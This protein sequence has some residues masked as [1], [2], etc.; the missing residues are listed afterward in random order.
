VHQVF[1]CTQALKYEFKF[2]ISTLWLKKISAC[3]TTPFFIFKLFWKLKDSG[4]VIFQSKVFSSRE[5]K[6][7][8]N[9]FFIT[10]KM[11]D[12][13]IFFELDT[14]FLIDFFFFVLFRPY[15]IKFFFKWI[16]FQEKE[17]FFFLFSHLIIITFFI[18]KIS[19]VLFSITNIRVYS[20]FFQFS[21]LLLHKKW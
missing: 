17:D 11:H 7:G 2:F 6:F 1:L 3:V 21:V 5:I 18:Q 13:L 16:Y 19:Y 20:L 15:I 9:T 4:V 10:Y 8:F 12:M 14:F